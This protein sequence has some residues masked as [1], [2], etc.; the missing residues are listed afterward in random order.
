MSDLFTNEPT[1]NQHQNA[2]LA[3]RLRPQTLAEVIGQKHLLK[4]GQPLAV[5]GVWRRVVGGI[6]CQRHQPQHDAGRAAGN[7]RRHR[8]RQTDRDGWLVAL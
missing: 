1:H 5:A 6:F 2:P 4:S 3:E 8:W 7:F